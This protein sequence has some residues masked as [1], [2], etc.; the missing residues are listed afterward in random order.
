[1]L[2]LNKKHQICLL[3]LNKFR[4]FAVKKSK[5]GNHKRHN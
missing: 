2:P 3:A 1:M 5:Y 4:V